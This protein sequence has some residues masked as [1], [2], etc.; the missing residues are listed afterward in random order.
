[1]TKTGNRYQLSYSTGGTPFTA[2]Y[3]TGAPL[4]DVNVGTFAVGTTT[5]RASYDYFR[6]SGQSQTATIPPLPTTPAAPGTTPPAGRPDKTPPFLRLRSNARQRL[7]TLR[8]R[9]LTFR[10]SANEPVAKLEATLL[11]RLSSK[12]KRHAARRLARQTVRNVK[13]GQIVSLKLRPSATLRKRLAR[14]K[15]LPAL[16]RIRATDAAGNVTTR[17]KPLTFR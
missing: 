11:G 12:G 6:F 3:E 1:M 15:R 2:V 10:V 8:T 14:E 5:V 9:G 7:R 16:L 4:E 13:S 17:T